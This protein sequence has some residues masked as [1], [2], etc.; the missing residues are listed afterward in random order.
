[1]IEYPRS[2]GGLDYHHN[3]PLIGE[4][5]TNDYTH[6]HRSIDQLRSLNERGILNTNHFQNVL[7][8][9]VTSPAIIN[10]VYHEIKLVDDKSLEYQTKVIRRTGD[11]QEMHDA[12]YTKKD[13]KYGTNGFRSSHSPP[14]APQPQ[15]IHYA[16]SPT[17][18]LH[19]AI[20]SN[21]SAYSSNSATMHSS[22]TDGQMKSTKV[23]WLIHFFCCIFAL[24]LLLVLSM[25][26]LQI[27]IFSVSFF[28]S[29]SVVI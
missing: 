6:F 16:L 22:S 8:P 23:G 17:S 20:Q 7:G 9:A 11:E 2:G 4:I 25:M 1:M 10:G 3:S 24:L 29:P 15:H 14:V 12:S 5:P 19:T 18:P 28:S 21:A 26:V 13:N 27:F